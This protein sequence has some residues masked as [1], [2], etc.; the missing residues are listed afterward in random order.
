[1]TKMMRN[2]ISIDEE[3]CDGC[4]L[5]IA[6][7]AEGAIE[8]MGGK[9]RLVSEKYCDGL[10]ACLGECPKGAIAMTQREAEA[11]DEDAVE[12]RLEAI[13]AEAVDR[14]FRNGQGAN[15]GCGCPGT[16]MAAFVPK[17]GKPSAPTQV[18]GESAL[19]H[20]PVQIR[21]VPPH[22][23][24]LKGAELLV[25]ADCAPAAFPRLHQELLP[26]RVILIGCPKFDDVQDYTRRFTE[27]FQQAGIRNVTVLSMEVPCC[28]GLAQIVRQAMF[29]AGAR[30]PLQEMIVTRQG[31]LSEQRRHEEPGAKSH[32]TPSLLEAD[33]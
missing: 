10:G 11:Y 31:E 8:I 23:S 26:G 22:A 18:S 3:L 20:W 24:F 27:I 4:G 17:Q 19:S 33:N 5:C 32:F 2:I 16:A 6:G 30:I 1:M 29:A 7:C 13:K 25:A 9:A 21:L 15:P 14:V 12:Q 28:A